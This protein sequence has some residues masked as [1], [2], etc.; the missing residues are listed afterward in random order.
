MFTSYSQLLRLCPASGLEIR[1]RCEN[2]QEKIELY[3]SFN[4]KKFLTEKRNARV[5]GEATERALLKRIELKNFW[6]IP[7]DQLSSPVSPVVWVR[8]LGDEP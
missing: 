3:F 1:N 2:R 6:F 8:F 7:A 5:P 4:E